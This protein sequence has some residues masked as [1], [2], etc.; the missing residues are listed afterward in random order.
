MKS[1]S[2]RQRA[3]R[4]APP[5]YVIARRSKG[6]LELLRIP[7]R[8]GEKALPIFSFEELAQGFLKHR[9]LGPEWHIRKSYNGEM[10]S[11][12]L[13]PCTDVERIL[14]NPL[15]DPLAAQGALL[16]SMDRER[17]MDFLLTARES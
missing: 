3:P 7:L 17:F 15:P 9:G 1:I 14:P 11:L 4:R 6:S 5:Q 10:I 16:N 12:L 2:E 13:G 8:A